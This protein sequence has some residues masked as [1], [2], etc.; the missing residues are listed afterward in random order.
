MATMADVARLSGVSSSTVS[1]VLNG[2]R[3]VNAETR[4]RVEH[5]V[6]ELGYRRN[7]AA[8]TLAGGSS[9]TIGLAI[10]GLTNPY[11]G[12]LLHAIE[13]R[14]SA[15]GFVLV[16][17]DTHDEDAM[18]HRVVESLIDRNVDGL[19]VAPS[20][21][22]I[23]VVGPLVQQ[24]GTPLVLLDRG[25]DWPCDQVTPENRQ[26]ARTLTEHL[27]EHG[28]RR[29]AVVSGLQGLDST[30]ERLAGYRDALV[31]AR[32]D[33]DERLILHADSSTETAEALVYELL[34]EPDPPTAL[35]SLNNAM[36]IGTLRAA[37][38]TARHIPRDLAFAAYDDFEWSDLF[39][40]GLTA[41]AQDVVRLGNETVD[42]LLS[43]IAGSDAP[44]THRV[45]ETSFHR[46]TSCGCTP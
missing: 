15:A 29:I 25:L 32:I 5:A 27:I 9:H 42:L 12:P 10:S 16:L 44:F 38:R 6:S 31:A 11:F 43:R 40:P 20:R 22:F 23:D 24:S 30:R 41:I 7:T 3:H 8:R 18:E 19:I 46:R 39:E 28:H 33:A 35:V 17:G 1:H 37:R 2:T 34:S 13:Q 45:I 21:G 4:G 36:T 14:V 26:S